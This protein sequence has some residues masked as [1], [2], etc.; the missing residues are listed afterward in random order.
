[1]RLSLALLAVEAKQPRIV[2]VDGE[3]ADWLERVHG[4]LVPVVQEHCPDLDCIESYAERERVALLEH[5]D[6]GITA[7]R[8]MRGTNLRPF[9]RE[10]QLLIGD[11]WRAYLQAGAVVSKELSRL[12]SALHSVL[13]DIESY[14]D[15]ETYAWGG[16]AAQCGRGPTRDRGLRSAANGSTSCDAGERA[17]E[18]TEGQAR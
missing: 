1:V 5:E 9:M 7:L 3:C 13:S 17:G 12:L 15:F 16:H 14:K 10:L 18:G 2:S 11:P 8:N 4:M 6:D